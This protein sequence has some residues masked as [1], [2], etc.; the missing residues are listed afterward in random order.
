MDLTGNLTASVKAQG[1]YMG[2]YHSLREWFH[3]LYLQ[4]LKIVNK[5]I[6]NI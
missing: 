2:L 4:V 5:Y 1:L 6:M 3:P